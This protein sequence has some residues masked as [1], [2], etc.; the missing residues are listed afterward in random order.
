MNIVTSEL[1]EKQLKDILNIIGENSYEAAKSFKTYL[2][3]IVLNIPSKEKKYKKSIYFN[4]ENIKDVEFQGCRIVFFKDEPKE[5]FMI[6][7]I[8][9]KS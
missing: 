6:L 3:T 2:D 9:A 7:G 1:Y 4:D 5:R 8:T